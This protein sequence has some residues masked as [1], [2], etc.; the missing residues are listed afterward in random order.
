MRYHELRKRPRTEGRGKS[1][2]Y[3]NLPLLS[4]TGHGECFKVAGRGRLCI[5]ACTD[6]SQ[7]ASHLKQNFYDNSMWKLAVAVIVRAIA[8][9]PCGRTKSRLTRKTAPKLHWLK[10]NCTTLWTFI[11]HSSFCSVPYYTFA[12]RIRTLFQVYPV[13]ST[14]PPIQVGRQVYPVGPKCSPKA[15]VPLN[16]QTSQGNILGSRM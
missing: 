11:F 7:R 16:I 6:D 14:L 3:T 12:S 5:S 9:Q 8:A 2:E 10:I 1:K 13:A 4:E 15:T